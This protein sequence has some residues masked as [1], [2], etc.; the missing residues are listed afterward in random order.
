MNKVSEFKSLSIGDKNLIVGHA[1]ICI[2]TLLVSMGTI[3]KMANDL[4]T[5]VSTIHPNGVR[6]VDSS[7]SSASY[8]DL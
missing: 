5:S 2:G 4:P 7:K 3:F 1:L 8:F 6:S